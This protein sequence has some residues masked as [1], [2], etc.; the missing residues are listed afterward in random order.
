MALESRLNYSREGSQAVTTPL[1]VPCE[2]R[3]VQSNLQAVSN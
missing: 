2:Q 1:E 3:F